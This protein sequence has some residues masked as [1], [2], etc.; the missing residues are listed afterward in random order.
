LKNNQ[1]INLK[2]VR[3]ELGQ[4]ESFIDMISDEK[5]GWLDAIQELQNEAQYIVGHAILAAAIRTY[6][7]RLSE[8]VRTLLLQDWVQFMHDKGVVVD[9][10]LAPEDKLDSDH[11]P[12]GETRNPANHIV[13]DS[14]VSVPAADIAHSAAETGLAAESSGASQ[15]P[16]TPGRTSNVPELPRGPV[17]AGFELTT[18]LPLMLNSRAMM[19]GAQQGDDDYLLINSSMLY[20]QA[21]WVLLV[22]PHGLGMLHLRRILYEQP[23]GKS[24][25]EGTKALPPAII[26]LQHGRRAWHVVSAELEKA[27]AA[28]Q[29]CVLFNAPDVVSNE[30]EQFLRLAFANTTRGVDPSQL[31]LDENDTVTPVALPVQL[32]IVAR[33]AML[34]S[35]LANLGSVL[36]VVSYMHPPAATYRCYLSALLHQQYMPGEHAEH[37][38]LLVRADTLRAEASRA[39]QALVLKFDRASGLDPDAVLAL[40]K[41]KRKM[42]TLLQ[43]T[44]RRLLKP[45]SGLAM[46]EEITSHC[47]NL[48]VVAGAF[49]DHSA[50]G[51]IAADAVMSAFL[52]DLPVAD[53]AAEG[54]LRNVVAWTPRALCSG[55]RVM[56][57]ALDR[58]AITAFDALFFTS[59]WLPWIRHHDYGS[60]VDG[61]SGSRGT[62]GSLC[63]VRGE[64]WGLPLPLTQPLCHFLLSGLDLEP[65]V[66]NYSSLPALFEGGE[67]LSSELMPSVDGRRRPL[68]VSERQQAAAVRLPWVTPEQQHRLLLLDLVLSASGLSCQMMQQLQGNTD[69]WQRWLGSGMRDSPP[70]LVPL[71]AEVPGEVVKEWRTWEALFV[72]RCFSPDVAIEL[73]AAVVD[74]RLPL[75]ARAETQSPEGLL[76]VLEELTEPRAVVDAAVDMAGAASRS[77]A[78]EK[79][80]SVASWVEELHQGDSAAYSAGNAANNQPDKTERNAGGGADAN[81]NAAFAQSGPMIL[82]MVSMTDAADEEAEPDTRRSGSVEAQ[83]TI[84][85]DLWGRHSLRCRPVLFLIE[86][87]Y[88]AGLDVAFCLEEIA[89]QRGALL[90]DAGLGRAASATLAEFGSAARGDGEGEHNDELVWTFVADVHLQPAL[91]DVLV[92]HGLPRQHSQRQLFITCEAH[93]SLPE[94]LLRACHVVRVRQDASAKGQLLR[95]LPHAKQLRRAARAEALPDKALALLLCGHA[96]IQSVQLRRSWSIFASLSQGD[97]LAAIARLAARSNPINEAGSDFVALLRKALAAEYRRNLSAAWDALSAE[98]LLNIFLVGENTRDAERHL[99]LV[100]S[101]ASGEESALTEVPADTSKPL[102]DAWVRVGDTLEDMV[103]RVLR[104]GEQPIGVPDDVFAAAM[105]SSTSLRPPGTQ[106]PVLAGSAPS[107]GDRSRI[108]LA[109]GDATLRSSPTPSVGHLSRP[110]SS[111]VNGGRTSQH[112]SAPVTDYV[113]S[114]ASLESHGLASRLGQLYNMLSQQQKPR[115]GLSTL[116]QRDL[117]QRW[118]EVQLPLLESTA[119]ACEAMLRREAPSSMSLLSAVYAEEHRQCA[120]AL[121]HLWRAMSQLAVRLGSNTILIGEIANVLHCLAENRLPTS[122][123]RQF[124]SDIEMLENWMAQ[125]MRRWEVLES[126][127]AVDYAEPKVSRGWGAQTRTYQSHTVLTPSRPSFPLHRLVCPP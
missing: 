1:E 11:G 58:E 114:R 101:A 85:P 3:A 77:L 38:G 37:A 75:E 118:L 4:A 104:V 32:Y 17:T 106:T 52:R 86:Q 82:P 16:A 112:A 27:I 65:R 94:A 59:V 76:S 74:A 29:P 7:P 10:Y 105:G 47:A 63:Q 53:A 14:K 20:W 46:C 12:Q 127:A 49:A 98:A 88:V 48:C 57:R 35:W 120:I 8:P 56:R 79:A 55:A 23:L 97:L 90:V 26:D 73:L 54:D 84:L 6:L 2:T 39:T 123:S 62:V 103:Q 87:G 44:H 113:V 116:E 18:V 93:A 96:A 40:V 99:G 22:D 15:Q 64:Q 81:A 121:V 50:Q 28:Q 13:G 43:E 102:S 25:K 51:Y 126:A 95:L 107:G 33:T 42:Q 19:Q 108:E 125:Q 5:Q 110:T 71:S 66:P 70:A 80:S 69:A 89:T 9:R 45:R 109:G 115:E 78:E 31:S 72:T 41:T 100:G 60:T 68:A 24:Y 122:W 21:K 61:A 30:L 67:V 119:E 92:R 117:A 124:P 111:G 91:W 36:S 34:D 83:D